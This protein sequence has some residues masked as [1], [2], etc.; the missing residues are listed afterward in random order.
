MIRVTRKILVEI[1]IDESDAKKLYDNLN[2]V[3]KPHSVANDLLDLLGKQLFPPD[4]R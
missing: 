3:S 1:E 4:M 2:S